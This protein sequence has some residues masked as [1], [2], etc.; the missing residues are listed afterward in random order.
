VTGEVGP[1]RT[2]AWLRRSVAA[3]L[4]GTMLAGG[5]AL[6]MRDEIA[7]LW[8][9]NTLFEPE[10]IVANFSHMDRAFLSVDLPA[11]EAS[12]PLPA[13]PAATLPAGAAAWIEARAVTG[14]VV[15]HRG[16]V[17]HE[18]Y[19]LGTGPQ[20]RRI[21]W[22]IAKSF[23][24]LL[25]GVLIEEG[26][27]ALDEP[28]TRRVPELSGTAYE[29]VTLRDVLAMCSGVAFD[30]DYLDPESDINRMGRVLALGGS[31]D[32]FAASLDLRERPPGEVMRYV[33]IDTHVAG[34]VLRR[35]TGRDIPEMMAERITGPMGIGAGPMRAYYLTDGDGTAFVLGGLNMR[36]RDYARLGQLVVDG[37]RA[38]GRQIVPEAWIDE[39]TRAQ[40]P[41][42]PGQ[43]RYG[44]QWW[45]PED[46]RPGE[47]V[48][49]GIYGQHVYVDRARQVVI[50]V[51][52]ADRA[53][54]AEGAFEA[55]VD[56]FRAIAAA[57]A[58]G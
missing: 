33:S 24:S 38:G 42:L 26:A 54:R 36:T 32:A 16:A 55:Q 18:S 17:V 57:I 50:A 9:V 7:R 23:L 39:S 37:G 2:R 48:A 4:A 56:M 25:A 43:P 45:L 46:G 28:V 49:R 3:L 44:F 13:G 15:L 6:W 41:T 20:D 11:A 52:A 53:F 12:A 58:D 5:G 21:S 22:S 34:M 40:V 1:V 19:H 8:A 51:N 14:L 35:A 31:M 30:E 10:R 27:V 29:G 47:V